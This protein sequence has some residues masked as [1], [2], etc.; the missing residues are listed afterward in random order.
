MQTK[1]LK[2]F[3][4]MELSIAM[5]IAAICIGMAFYMFQ[6]FQKLYLDQQHEKQEQFSFALFQHLLKRDMQQAT[7]IFYEES[8]LVLQD[9]T[10]TIRYQFDPKYI[11]R[12]HYQQHTDT[13]NLKMIAVDGF[14]RQM[15]RP[16]PSCID[17]L[18]FTIAFDKNEHSFIFDKKYAA[19]ELMHIAQTKQD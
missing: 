7:A 4:L 6:F 17:E 15:A 11:I 19:L 18:H 16:S 5:L 1:K 3:T 8:E 13:F 9:T 12:D 10:G 2:A 14:Y